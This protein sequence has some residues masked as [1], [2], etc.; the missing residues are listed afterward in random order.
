MK[1]CWNGIRSEKQNCAAHFLKLGG[2][3]SARPAGIDSGKLEEDL[4][5]LVRTITYAILFVGLILVFVPARLLSWSGIAQPEI[6]GLWQA[7]GMAV[8]ALGAALVLWCLLAFVRE[9]KGTPAPFDP[10]RRLV[11][12]GPYRF[13]R[14]PMYE[15]AGLA[16]IGAALFYESY[17]LLAYS[18]LFFIVTHLFVVFNEEPRLTISFGQDYIAYC[19]TVGRWLPRL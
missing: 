1:S 18:G 5:I 19:K 12:L 3:S 8:S 17:S 11:V 16:L 4:S 10:P 13:V 7:G 14:N 15:G 6:M 2:T 9:G